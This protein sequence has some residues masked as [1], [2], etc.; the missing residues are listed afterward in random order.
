MKNSSYSCVGVNVLPDCTYF[1]IMG[2]MVFKNIKDKVFYVGNCEH[3]NREGILNFM[4]HNFDKKNCTYKI[5]SIQ[6]K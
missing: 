3:S 4:L 1:E 2:K 5:P 6:T